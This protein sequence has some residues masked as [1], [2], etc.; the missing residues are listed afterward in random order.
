[1]AA[2]ALWMGFTPALLQYLVLSAFLGGVLTIAIL[3]FRGSPLALAMGAR[4]AL[5]HLTDTKTGIPYGIALG[6][7]GLLVCPESALMIWAIGN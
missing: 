4:G 7:A 6:V 5:P 3:I 1:M 2:T